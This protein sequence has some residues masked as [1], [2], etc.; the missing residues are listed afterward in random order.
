MA[1]AFVAGEE[2]PLKEGWLVKQGGRYKSWKRRYFILKPDALLYFKS[3]L[4]LKDTPLGR[5]PLSTILRVESVA[6]ETVAKSKKNTPFFK[7][8]IT[9]T[10]GYYLIEGETISQVNEWIA[11]IKKAIV[12]TGRVSVLATSHM[13]SE[14]VSTEEVDDEIESPRGQQKAGGGQAPQNRV[15]ILADAMDALETEEKKEREVQMKKRGM[16]LVPMIQRVNTDGGAEEEEAEGDESVEVNSR[17]LYY[18]VANGNQSATKALLGLNSD[19]NWRNPAEANRTCLHVAAASGDTAIFEL[20]VKQTKWVDSYDTLGWSPLHIAAYHGHAAIIK[21]WFEHM[22]NTDLSEKDKEKHT[23]F[24]LAVLGGHTECASLI[25][26]RLIQNSPND[27]SLKVL[28]A[29]L[30]GETDK[31]ATT[32]M[33]GGSISVTGECGLTALHLAASSGKSECVGQLLK[34]GADV[35]CVD[36]LSKSPLHHAACRGD[37]PTVSI[38]L[39]HGAKVDAHDNRLK[40]PL[41]LAAGRGHT[42]CV[43]KLIEK[44]A[45]TQAV[46]ESNF[47][48]IHV[49]A[50]HGKKAII[51]LLLSKTP[52]INVNVTAVERISP[53]LLAAHGGHPPCVKLLHEHGADLNLAMD[54]G[55]TPLHEAVING[56][57]ETMSTLIDLG[58]QL[59]LADE[60][61]NTPLHLAV[62]NEKIEAVAYLI[63]RGANVDRQNQAGT[64]PLRLAVQ[65]FKSDILNLLLEAGADIHICVDSTSLLHEAAELGFFFGVRMLVERGAKPDVLDKNNWTPLM[66][67]ASNNHLSIVTYLIAK[68]AQV[69]HKATNGWAAIHGAAALNRIETLRLLLEKGASVTT[70][71][72]DGMTPLHHAGINGAKE[73]LLLL[74]EHGAP[75][76]AQDNHKHTPIQKAAVNNQSGC[77]A[78]LIAHGAAIDKASE[79]CIKTLM[80]TIAGEPAGRTE[81]E[82]LNA[83]IKELQAKLA[84]YESSSSSHSKEKHSRSK[85]EDRK[86]SH[87]K[88]KHHSRSKKESSASRTKRE[89]KDEKKKDGSTT[90]TSTPPATSVSA[91]A[92]ASAASPV[93]SSG[94]DSQETPSS[95]S[96]SPSSEAPQPAT[97][98]TPAEPASEDSKASS[99]PEKSKAPAEA[100]PD[101]KES[102]AS[103]AKHYIQR[104]QSILSKDEYKQ[105][106]SLLKDYKNRKIT[107]DILIQQIKTLFSGPEKSVLLAGFVTFIPP[108]FRQRYRDE[109]SA[110]EQQQQQEQ[111]AASSSSSSETPS[112][113]AS[114]AAAP[115]DS[116]RDRKSVV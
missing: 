19:S 33:S 104:A 11:A 46:D 8:V 51:E 16:T 102:Q 67:A 12:Q 44:G 84:A 3:N 90:E 9:G 36:L 83:K 110:I 77:V 39:E 73:C 96:T 26:E 100:N 17:E 65:H 75:I 42:G 88:D 68:G 23:P 58:A 63:E 111:Q 25:L 50:T 87:S 99:E 115:A 86:V 53:V 38:L 114:S 60:E 103:V 48:P 66:K 113:E 43:A 52:G 93:Q 49:A 34:L 105:F 29:A 59:D 24:Y 76:N 80:K 106:Q 27:G 28:S 97:V 14:E 62:S 89:D 54:G 78:M 61:G 20:I 4:K 116:P 91:L 85:K 37:I 69:N 15:D 95:S 21:L 45:N 41:H 82:E 7:I 81:V 6:G 31:I 79:E 35:N 64:T 10:R 74:L 101:D 92:V 70:A 22:N 13:S 108:K 107:I 47:A 94:P 32:I 112:T 72:D 40:T 18:A 57:K 5:I 71:D 55:R 98:S 1:H 30:H 2:V 56:D 109:L